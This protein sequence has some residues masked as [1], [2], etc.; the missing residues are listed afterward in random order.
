MEPIAII[1]IG[2][3]FPGAP[4]P[5]AFWQLLCDGVDAV[6]EVPAD[7]W[8]VNAFYDP[9]P[10]C[11]GK[12][13]TRWGGFLAQVDR[14]DPQFFGI[15]PK[16]A[17][18]MDPQQR[19]L[20]ELTW[21]ALEHAGQ[22][23]EKLT[24]SQTGVFIGIASNDYY[25]LLQGGADPLNAYMGTGNALS[26]AAN[27]ISYLFDWRGPSLAIDTA[28]SS[29]LVATHL[30]CQ[31]LGN[32]DTNLAVAG[33]V[34]LILRP[35][36][37]LIFSKARMM[38]PD[39]RC[40]TFDAQANGYVRGEGGGIIV[41]KRLADAERDGDRV[42]A[43]IRGTAINQDG[44]S[45]GLTAPNGPS[46]VAV[47]R[48][49]MEK[50]GVSPDQI[51]YVEAHGTGTTLGDPIEADALGAV[52]AQGH[53]LTQRCVV[54]SVKTNI[55]HLEAA[56]GIAGLIKV[57]LSLQHRL[58]PPSLHFQTPNPLIPLDKLPLRV[59]Q[60]LEAWPEPDQVGGA[61]VSSF[62]FGGAN[63]HIILTEPPPPLPV[64]PA[65]DRPL[66]L[67][68][69]AR[70]PAALQALAQKYRDWL[71]PTGAGAGLALADVTYT[72][73]CRRNHHDHRLAI[74]A[75]D[76]E[77]LLARLD[78]F[79][80]GETHAGL[81]SGKKRQR[82]PK[83]TF[84]FSG[85][86]SQW[87]GMGRELWQNEPVFR[88][89]LEQCDALLQ[90]L[91]GWSLITELTRTEA[92]SRLESTAI[93]QPA[94]FAVQVALVALWRSWGIQP[95]AIVGHS[96]G[97]VAAAHIAG[98]LSLETAVQVIFHRGRLMQQ[99]TGTGKMAAVELDAAAAEALIANYDGQLAIAAINSPSSVVLSGV[100]AA[101]EDVVQVLQS[102]SISARPLR[103]DY[104]FHS[105]QMEPFQAELVEL[106]SDLQP[107]PAQIPL[108]STV[109]GQAI[110][111]E[112]LDAIYWG[113]NIREP[114]QFAP[115]IDALVRSR[116]TV[117]LEISPHPLLALN[118]SQCLQYAEQTG[119]VLPSLRRQEAERVGLLSTLGSLYTLGYPVN[120][121]CL[122]PTGQCLPL[123]AYPWQRERYWIDDEGQSPP[124]LAGSASVGSAPRPSEHSL[125]PNGKSAT[126]TA[127]NSAPLMGLERDQVLAL[128]ETDRSSYLETYY[129]TLLG[130]VMGLSAKRLD[131][132]QPLY[133][134]G[135]DS[136]MAV[137]LRKQI[138]A[139][140]GVVVEWEQF[141][142]LTADRFTSL[143]LAQLTATPAP[144]AAAQSQTSRWI[145]PS[146]PSTHA[147]L[148]LFCFPYAGAGAS[149]FRTWAADL[150]PDIELCPVQLPGRET[151]FAEPALT[152]LS[153]LVQAL[154][155]HL[156]P[157]LDQPF[158][159]FGH[160]LGALISF[161]LTRELRR[162]NAPGPVHLFVSGCRAPQFPDP[163]RPIH[164]LPEPKFLAA[165][166]HLNGT[167]ADVLHHPEL[168]QRFLPALRADFALLETYVY[169]ADQRLDCPITAFG[170]TQDPKASLEDLSGWRDQT[171]DSFNLQLFPGDHF[172]MHENRQPLLQALTQPLTQ[173]LSP[174][175]LLAP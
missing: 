97:E 5:E 48:Q 103:V 61:G 22:V 92:D 7:R 98:V 168:M 123:P 171:Q 156:R 36:L 69:S 105:T 55:G 144:I 19:L 106:L 10:D 38:S 14:F 154:A 152:R 138:E 15:A 30:A 34:N 40:K 155:K 79:A 141:P 169:T 142:G 113:R 115:V 56:A 76:R 101:I 1:G 89:V 27:R 58:I 52:M 81:A 37:T 90:P 109:M 94:L 146:G 80:Q 20:L 153:P 74:A 45:N 173:P 162:Q 24:R 148:R 139:Q 6:T 137:E 160:S 12:M 151:R 21:E 87:W 62:G 91:A 75:S 46:Q 35:E 114:V 23:P 59:P 131:G 112:T 3:R 127:T 107:Q 16:E 32:G 50:A 64:V 95:D 9:D 33:G 43:V 134:M 11:R 82:P 130:R 57:A 140:L 93:A 121:D 4:D 158:A 132:Q 96:L 26:I 85:Q 29:S 63:A 44:H 147:R 78:A 68:L 170:G 53:S 136:L 125:R 122:Y 104:A 72:A 18:Y 25:Q 165:L 49:A 31:S 126:T 17:I 157:H 83:L 86:G 133:T 102:Q 77:G 28:C 73:S 166:Q 119:G 66:L 145:A 120:W 124:P 42:L 88:A 2:C 110:V 161:E 111:G 108:W 67:P 71:A 116:H 60:S 149:I 172:F 143:V 163:D 164:R 41:L 175:L 47:I 13:N 65:V 39:G 167:P 118:L 128:A 150:P 99:G 174:P 100:P 54:G 117:F 129:K 84:V 51:H 135:L 8:D 159:F 70:S